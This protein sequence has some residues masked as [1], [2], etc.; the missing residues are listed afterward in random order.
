MKIKSVHAFEG[1]NVYSLKPVV[2]AIV[3]VE[4]LYDTPTKDIINFNINL[5]NAFPGLKK[6]GC[7][8]GYEGGFLERLEEGTYLPHV[9]EHTIIELQNLLGYEVA[10]GKARET[11]NPREYMVVYEYKNGIIAKEC[12]RRVTDIFNRFITQESP[13]IDECIKELKNMAAITD[14]GPSTVALYNE[15]KK[16]Q[17]PVKR[18]GLGSLLQLGYGKY[19][20]FIQASMT[21]SASCID[22]DIAGDKQLTK[23][24]L[25]RNDI[26]VP[27][28]QV[29]YSDLSAVYAAEEIG[30]PVVVKPLD[31]NQG[32]G[33]T[34]CITK[35]S[36]VKEACSK[37][38]KYSK[39]IIVERYYP[40]SDYRVLVIGDRVAAVAMRRPPSLK[41]N[42]VNSVN[43]LIE[44]ENKSILRGEDH[45]KPLTKIK[46]DE[47]A[48]EVLKKQGFHKD[49]IPFDGQ[50]VLLR[51]NG[52]LSTGGTA[53]NCTDK[54]HP[55]NCEIAIKAAK[56]LKIDIAG[57]DITA[58]DITQPIGAS[59]GAVI[60]VNAAPGLRMHIHP[61][62]GESINVAGKIMDL[63]YPDVKKASIPI[64][65]ITG[66]NG[67][68]T[69][70]RMI[71][72][73]L[74]IKGKTVGMTTTSGTYIDGE[75]IAKGD[76]TGPNS[77]QQILCDK[78]VEAAVLETARGG[79]VKR[80][81]GYELADVGVIVNVSEDH[82]GIDGI[83]S[84]EEMAFVKSLVIEAVKED[85][86]CVLNADDKMTP[87]LM[88]R[89]KAEI[90]FFSKRADNEIL[91]EHLKNGGIG[92]TLEDGILTLIKGTKVTPIIPVN[93]IP[94]TLDGKIECN[95]ENSMAAAA[96]LYGLGLKATDIKKGLLSFSTDIRSNPGRFNIFDFQGFKVML[97]YSHNPHGY[98]AVGEFIKK[99]NAKRLVGI[100]G[101]P[102]D[103]QDE[104]VSEVG[105][106]SS[107]MFDR[108]YLKEDA[109]LRGRNPGEIA[110]ILYDSVIK[111]GMEPWNV[112]IIY[113]EVKALE[114]AIENSE[115]GD[116]IV[117]FYE[118][119]EEVLKTVNNYM[120]KTESTDEAKIK[121]VSA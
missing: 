8:L 115:E 116:F 42:G 39:G 112:D 48:I 22:V 25:M 103:R 89:A 19:Q 58:L 121:D 79:I 78:R 28:G 6:H 100:I 32:K 81:L 57:I 60:E 59:N 24:I 118:N 117:V 41:G 35:E 106:I 29:C 9:L 119:Y 95:I 110:D 43:E 2:K 107:G 70:T 16:R 76:N 96:A 108:L 65:S 93:M 102:G 74:K 47:I 87:Y 105:R 91:L 21:D 13:E 11:I 83:E 64:V 88:K 72:H 104:L 114:T 30:Y 14:L 61:S 53:V 34:L 52:N 3:D 26:P 49:Y 94:A 50:T 75:R 120:K 23:K 12:L 27:E 98:K 86:Y 7:C 101:V 69:T 73:T 84:L 90:I 97:D 17:I 40:G 51:E 99:V 18:I 63:M 20:R 66:T 37:A 45:E 15:A 71:A 68:T 1:S 55:Y 109:D 31:S 67:K 33:V 80:G 85:G 92:V 111:A 4:E 5:L 10:F 36:E 113:S 38:F 46:L 54:I 44:I 77:A 82:L 62:E 56:C